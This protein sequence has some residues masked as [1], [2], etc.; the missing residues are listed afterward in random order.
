MRPLDRDGI[1]A[2]LMTIEST[3]KADDEGNAAHL[4][5]I[6]LIEIDGGEE[7]NGMTYRV[8]DSGKRILEIY[9]RIGSI[10]TP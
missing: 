8:T 2:T 9:R 3:S 5:E 6:G 4:L 7:C 1:F 10:I